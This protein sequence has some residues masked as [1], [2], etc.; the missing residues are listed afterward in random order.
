MAPP[1][2]SHDAGIQNGGGYIEFRA[3]QI[4]FEVVM[5]ILRQI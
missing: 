2:L 5:Q 1:D 4:S 3:K